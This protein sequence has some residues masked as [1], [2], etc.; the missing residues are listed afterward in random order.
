MMNSSV[1]VKTFALYM[2]VNLTHFL[3][4][5]YGVRKGK[6]LYD[7]T[8]FEYLNKLM[9]IGIM[10]CFCLSSVSKMVALARGT[11]IVAK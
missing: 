6:A 8:K 3:L 7:C 9:L 2:F 10:G 11:A 5:V 4:E 1:I